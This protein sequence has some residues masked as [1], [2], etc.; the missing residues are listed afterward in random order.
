MNM[1]FWHG[2]LINSWKTQNLVNFS[3]KNLI[4]PA[5][6]YSKL[7]QTSKMKKTC[8]IDVLFSKICPQ[9]QTFD[10]QIICIHV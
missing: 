6:V 7:C 8:S 4:S 3:R 10:F 9:I 2:T 1:G 5:E